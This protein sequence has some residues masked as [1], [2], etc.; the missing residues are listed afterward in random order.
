MSTVPPPPPLLVLV[1]LEPVE[2]PPE[3]LGLLLL[4]LLLPQAAR[5]TIEA[6]T[7]QPVITF[8]RKLIVLLC[9]T[10]TLRRPG[11]RPI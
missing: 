6:A 7:A 1:V 9:S 11:R 10:R 3:L 8:P 5:A 2:P 4:E